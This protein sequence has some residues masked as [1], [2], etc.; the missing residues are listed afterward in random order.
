MVLIVGLADDDNDVQGIPVLT[1]D[2]LDGVLCCGNHIVKVLSCQMDGIQRI[3]QIGHGHTIAEGDVHQPSFC[4]IG[5]SAS[6]KTGISPDGCGSADNAYEQENSQQTSDDR[7]VQSLTDH[8]LETLSDD[9]HR[10]HNDES[11][12]GLEHAV[13]HHIGLEEA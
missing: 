7:Q 11:A 5:V 12:N 10:Q 3:A 8:F 2:I 1:A 13:S 6:Y 4:L 9:D